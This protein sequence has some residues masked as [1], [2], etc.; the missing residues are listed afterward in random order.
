MVQER[1][2]NGATDEPTSPFAL[3]SLQI[4]P[5][6]TKNIEF[7]AKVDM[8]APYEEKLKTQ[9]PLFIGLDHQIDTYFTVATGRLK[10]R[11]GN[12]ENTLIQYNRADT[13]DAKLS[14]IIL[15]H[16]TPDPALKAILV[17]QLGVKAVVDKKRKIYF[18][19]NIKFHFDEVKGLG[20]FIEVEVIDKDGSLST[21]D[22]KRDC[23]HYFQFFNL[24]QSQLID[25]S[26]SDLIMEKK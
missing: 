22:M 20:T 11:E 19:N 16:H 1:A 7:K 15:Y 23:A 12:I 3:F 6:N 26:Y 14:E 24:A 8:L 4:A 9:N 18:I 17:L 25:R 13:A 2:T 10:L 21:E 5:M